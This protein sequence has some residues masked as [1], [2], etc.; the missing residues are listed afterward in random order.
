MRNKNPDVIGSDLELRDD[1][2]EKMLQGN[3][4]SPVE[5]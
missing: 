4:R 1:S 5:L 2:P 3:L